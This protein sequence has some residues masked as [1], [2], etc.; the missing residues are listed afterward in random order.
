MN[1]STGSHRQNS[2]KKNIELSTA[3]PLGFFYMVIINIF[4]RFV[5]APTHVKIG[6]YFGALLVG[7]FLKDLNFFTQS[8]Y[9]AQKSNVFNKYFVKLGWAWTLAVCTPFI[10]MTSIV[11]TGCNQNSIRK[12]LFRLAVATVI[13]FVFTGVFDIIDSFTGNCI[14]PTH[15]TKVECKLNRHEWINGFDI[16]GHTFILMHSLFLML[17]EVRIFNQWDSFHKKL[18]EKLRNNDNSNIS[19]YSED[20][21]ERAEFWFKKLT[22][23]IKLNFFLM[24]LLALLWEAML[25]STFIYFHTIMHKLVAASFA[26]TCWFLTYK[27][28][29]ANKELFLSPGLPGEGTV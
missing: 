8:S 27:T 26:V 3:G 5:F 17:E 18:E 16:S 29:Y 14:K 12:N 22:P 6:V 15:K 1:K 2:R 23:Y 13:W 19:P 25:F 10:T 20:P 11:Y 4:K 7:S 21:I 24:A 28:W 9:L